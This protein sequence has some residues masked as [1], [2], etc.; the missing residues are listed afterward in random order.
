MAQYSHL[1][2]IRA[3]KMLSMSKRIST[4][5][6]AL[7]ITAVSVEAHAAYT[8]T[9]IATAGP[10]AVILDYEIDGAVVAIH[11]GLEIY[12]VTSG[13]K[14]TIVKTGDAAPTGTF[15]HFGPTVGF[16]SIS[17]GD[18]SLFGAYTGGQGI[19]SGSGGALTTIAKTGDATNEGA[20]ASISNFARNGSSDGQ[21]TFFAQYSGG[22]GIYRG[23]GGPLTTIVNSGD[24]AP[25]GG[26]DSA[27]LFNGLGQ[28]AAL[29]GARTAFIAGYP[30]G[31]GVFTEVAGS[32]TTIA[33]TGD[34]APSGMF[35]A[36]NP[37]S[38]HSISGDT[39][40]FKANYTGGSGIFTGNGGPLTTI[41]KTGDQAPSGTFTSLTAGGIAEQGNAVS[42]F[43][44]WAGGVGAFVSNGGS[45]ETVIKSGD[46]LFGQPLTSLGLNKIA[47]DPNGSGQIAFSYVLANGVSGVA[48]ATPVPEPRA[49]ALASAMLGVVVRR[50]RAL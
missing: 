42:F 31:Q 21:T 32:L 29:S 1:S 28:G 6:A 24:P 19:F 23:N 12:K 9:N 18:V 45:I 15:T 17:G 22:G 43:G 8:F 26:F 33:K 3:A 40:A 44:Q 10:N 47:L 30:T 13:V 7:L 25:V 4:L 20:I 11:G 36:P 5:L 37:F 34:A 16:I 27:N 41:V 46:L 38:Q 35:G 39:V 49:L 2:H 50:R 48:M 14:T